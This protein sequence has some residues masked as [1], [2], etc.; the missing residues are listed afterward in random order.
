MSSDWRGNRFHRNES[1]WR[2][3][4]FNPKLLPG[5]CWDR[6]FFYVDKVYEKKNI[7]QF[8]HPVQAHAVC[9]FLK[10]TLH[11]HS[12]SKVR[13]IEIFEFCVMVY[14]S[15]CKKLK[16]L[17]TYVAFQAVSTRLWLTF[18]SFIQ[19][20]MLWMITKN[21]T[22]FQIFLKISLAAMVKIFVEWGSLSIHLKFIPWILWWKK[23][24]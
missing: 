5:D 14:K 6:R 22:N 17:G 19:V 21:D 3:M 10:D 8:L 24:W 4:N 1:D 15:I 18:F 13:Y 7:L 23:I 9:S 12:Q 11:I 16:L 2:G 20:S